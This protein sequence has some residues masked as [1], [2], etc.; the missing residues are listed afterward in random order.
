[1]FRFDSFLRLQSRRFATAMMIL[2][3]VAT[4][5]VGCGGGG[6]G[7]SSATTSPG[8]TAATSPS[9]AAVAAPV[10]ASTLSGAVATPAPSPPPPPPPNP[11]PQQ[12]GVALPDLS[13][14]ELAQ[15]TAGQA[16]FHQVRTAA[17]GLGPVYN[18]VS[19]VACHSAPAAGGGSTLVETRFGETTDGVFNPLTDQ[20]GSLFH[21][22]SLPGTP[23]D[24]IPADA[25]VTAGRLTTPVFGFGLIEAIPDSAIT[26]YASQQQTQNPAA[27]GQVCLVTES[28]GKAHVGRFGW[29]CQHALLLDFSGDA[30]LNEIGVSNDVFPFKN[31]ANGAPVPVPLADVED[32]PDA[33]GVRDIDRLGNFM[34]LLQPA[35][36]TGVS[37]ERGGALFTS[38]GC[39]VCHHPSFGAVSTIPAIN[40]Q[41]V[42][43]YSDFLVHD[44]GTGDGIAQA[45]APT[46]KIRTAPLMGVSLQPR[47]LHDGSA[48]TLDEAIRRH[49][50]EAAASTAN[51]E[52]LSS[53]D[54]AALRAFL[55]SL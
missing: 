37:N 34:R 33:N 46:N 41:Q 42:P 30:L 11:P 3:G 53:T 52:A 54:Q 2:A 31:V 39:A 45:A 25:N 12:A 49:A 48:T 43:A 50:R 15:F 51:Y 16:T 13:A 22:F 35:H 6:S 38:I 21:F 7:G 1:M 55:D 40:G 47:F 18:N 20:G 36:G 4:S 29:K 19:C 24:V 44:V 27:A 14:T 17:T 26:E 10:P 9:T 28:D 32:K 23:R 5:L 8:Q